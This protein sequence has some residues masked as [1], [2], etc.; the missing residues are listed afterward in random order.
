MIPTT[1]ERKRRE[2][3]VEHCLTRRTLTVYKTKVEGKRILVGL[4]AD[5]KPVQRGR[6]EQPRSESRR[7][8]EIGRE[9]V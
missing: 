7:V 2:S 1:D 5:R 6:P 3:D 8:G 9:H 4:Q